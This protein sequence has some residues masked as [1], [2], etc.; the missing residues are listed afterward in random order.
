MRTYMQLCQ[1]DLGFLIHC[2]PPH[3]T[4]DV[5][6]EWIFEDQD[7]TRRLCNALGWDGGTIWQVIE[8]IE[9]KQK[10]LKYI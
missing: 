10:E 8:E 3:C 9:R 2:T 1:E 7:V 4:K 6:L 5:L